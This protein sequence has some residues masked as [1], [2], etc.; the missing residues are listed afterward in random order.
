M[1]FIHTL[2][3][4]AHELRTYCNSLGGELYNDSSI[5]NAISIVKRYIGIDWK[6]YVSFCDNKY[7]R[8][9]LP[10]TLENDEFEIF[11]ICWKE[12]QE[13]NI[14]KHP[15]GGCI[16][17]VLDGILREEIYKYKSSTKSS[18]KSNTQIYCGSRSLNNNSVSYIDNKLGM[19]KII[20]EDSNPERNPTLVDDEE[21]AISLHIY[22][23]PHFY[24]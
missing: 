19:H 7:N 2:G 10:F 5:R 14:H 20:N 8:I 13:T 22:S 12:G 16:L 21:P 3:S 18:T 23:P 4:L 11:L 17:K 24:D 9:K 1:G 6:E 15:K